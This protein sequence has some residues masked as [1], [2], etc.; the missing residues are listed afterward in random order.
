[1]LLLLDAFLKEDEEGKKNL[2]Y[3]TIYGI[4]NGAIVGRH[5]ILH[6]G[7]AETIELNEEQS[8]AIKEAYNTI[9]NN[10]KTTE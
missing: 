8:N 5:D 10:T 2:T 3:P 4:K 7:T 9:I 1:M 6:D